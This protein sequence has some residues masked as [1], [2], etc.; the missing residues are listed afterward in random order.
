MIEIKENTNNAEEFNY[1]IEK[2]IKETKLGNKIITI[3]KV[4]GGLSHRMYKVVTDKGIY[5]VKELNPNVMKRKETYSNFLFAEK[6]TDIAKMNGINAI[7]TNKINEKVIQEMN[8]S[9]F[10]IFDWIDGKI[11]KNEEITEEHCKIIGKI[12]AQIHNI[13]F[14]NIEDEKRKQIQIEEFDWNKYLKVAEYQN[15][16]FVT[17]LK[18][19][20]SLLYELNKK[21]NEG[22]IYAK[23]H[24]VISHTDLDRKNVIWQKNVPF[25]IDWEASGYINSTIELIQVAWYWSDG[26]I[27]NL[28][29]DKFK[30]IFEEYK[31]YYK[32]NMD[33][34]IDKLIYADIYSGLAWINYNLQRALCIECKCDKEEI[35]LAEDEIKCSIEEII[36]NESQMKQMIK[37]LK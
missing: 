15:S 11:L 20:I 12:L 6:V 21:A 14:S 8:N 1:L 27:G 36:Y 9:Y 28:N 13:D 18:D 35:Q 23:E 10:M 24:L 25:I 26:D 19:N 4:I 37:L 5:A 22:Q 34:N 3:D 29:Y 7:G 30:I 16:S 33:E 17:V 2:L 32:G 31:K